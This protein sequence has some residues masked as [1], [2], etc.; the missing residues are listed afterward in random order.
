MCSK[1]LVEMFN[2]GY[3]DPRVADDI[4]RCR[5]N[6][7]RRNRMVDYNTYGIIFAVWFKEIATVI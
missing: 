1:L 5:H 3:H 7:D 4:A 6:G 2:S